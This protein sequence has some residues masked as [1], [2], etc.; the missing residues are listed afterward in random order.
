MDKELAKIARP[1]ACPGGTL[2]C[3]VD[4][5]RDVWLRERRTLLGASDIAVLFGHGYKD[6]FALWADKS[7]RSVDVET[8]AMGRGRIFERE[9]IRLWIEHYAGFPVATQRKGLMRSR[10]SPHAGATVDALSVC[11]AGKCLVEAKSQ[12]DLSEWFGPDG[13]EI[14]PTGFQFQ[15]QWQLAV[16]G[17]AHLHF[18]A[19]GPRFKIVHRRMDRDEELIRA[20][21]VRGDAWWAAHVTADVPPRPSEKSAGLVKE[22]YRDAT[23]GAVRHL[24]DELADVVRRAKKL[25]GE[26]ATAKAEYDGLIATLQAELGQATELCWPDGEPIASWRPGAQIDGADAGWRKRHPV[27]TED[28]SSPV[29]TLTAANVRELIAAHPEALTEPKGLRFRRTWNWA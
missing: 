25:H 3:S 21:F 4:V 27:W 5:E 17:R 16:T 12:G 20:M 2:V 23:A 29:P 11:P 24:P 10:V 19:L 1:W 7:A 13:E 15:G 9:I 28:Y 14:V 6:E 18:V 26:L 8:E 22:L